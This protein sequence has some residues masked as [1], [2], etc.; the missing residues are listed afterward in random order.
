MQVAARPMGAHR[1]AHNLHHR[2]VSLR[3]AGMVAAA[4]QM[5]SDVNVAVE[6]TAAA[7][8]M[9]INSRLPYHSN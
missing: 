6:R 4:L 7:G 9:S 3:S 8:W 1:K 5:L 2:Y